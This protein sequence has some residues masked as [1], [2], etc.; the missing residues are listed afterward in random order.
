MHETC[1]SLSSFYSGV[2][3]SY[4]VALPTFKVS[5]PFPV[6]TSKAH[7]EVCL[8]G[9]SESGQGDNEDQPSH[10]VSLGQL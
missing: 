8:L 1:S 9:N 2:H 3:P 7:V 5:T 4:W 10:I 6:N